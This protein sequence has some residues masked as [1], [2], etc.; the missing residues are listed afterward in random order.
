MHLLGEKEIA[1]VIPLPKYGTNHA[2]SASSPFS[3]LSGFG[4]A[5]ADKEFRYE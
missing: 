5:Y 1:V 4:R 2:G 3:V